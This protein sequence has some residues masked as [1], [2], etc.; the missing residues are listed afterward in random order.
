MNKNMVVYLIACA[1]IFLSACRLFSSN[2]AKKSTDKLPP[3]THLVECRNSKLN[4]KGSK[5]SGDSHRGSVAIKKGELTI[6]EGVVSEGYFEIDMMSIA[7]NKE[8]EQSYASILIAHLGSADFFEVEQYT[9]AQLKIESVTKDSIS[10]VL[11]IKGVSKSIAF[12]YSMEKNGKNVS[13]A[14]SFTIDRTRWGI[15]YNSPSVFNDLGDY[16]IRDKI[17]FDIKLIASEQ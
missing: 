12:P 13:I 3:Y 16:A 2:G 10:G 17:L 14:S 8:L 15:E 7:V 1:F 11:T 5:D 4:W 6:I 9:T